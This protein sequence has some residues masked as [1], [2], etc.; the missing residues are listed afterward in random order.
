MKLLHIDSSILGDRSASRVLTQS[1]VERLKAA[2][3]GLEVKYWDLVTDALPHL[4][5]G[6][7]ANA[8]EVESARNAEALSDFLAA[9][10]IVIG[11]P[12]YNFSVSS[13]LKA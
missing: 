3:P 8:D 7:L 13:Q 4:S 10:V 5:V 9:D 1:L 6:S 11:A 2:T 12:M